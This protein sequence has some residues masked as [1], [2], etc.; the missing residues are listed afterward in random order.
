MSYTHTQ[1]ALQYHHY[2]TVQRI[3]QIIKIFTLYYESGIFSMGLPDFYWPP[4]NI[5]SS[6]SK[7]IGN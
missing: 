5:Y 6:I 1:F 7:V 4:G 3:K 2:I